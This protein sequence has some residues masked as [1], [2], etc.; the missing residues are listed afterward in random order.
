MIQ[1]SFISESGQIT[2]LIIFTKSNSIQVQKA[3]GIGECLADRVELRLC[4]NIMGITLGLC[5]QKQRCYTPFRSERQRC[6]MVSQPSG[7]DIV[8]DRIVNKVA[9]DLSA[10]MH[11]TNTR[12]Q[13]L[14]SHLFH[15]SISTVALSAA[16]LQ[17]YYPADEQNGVATALLACMWQVLG[18][19]FGWGTTGPD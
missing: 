16:C 12:Q 18:S 17:Y 14:L 1:G 13:P 3:E 2:I 8:I 7:Y 11:D 5:E 6:D 19:H 4:S 15:P 9:S 10:M